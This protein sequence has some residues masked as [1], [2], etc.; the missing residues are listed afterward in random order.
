MLLPSRITRSPE[1]LPQA[2]YLS[3]ILLLSLPR[4][5]SNS[6]ARVFKTRGPKSA[7]IQMT[8]LSLRPRVREKRLRGEERRC[9][10]PHPTPLKS[11]GAS[12]GLAPHRKATLRLH[13]HTRI[14]RWLPVADLEPSWLASTSLRCS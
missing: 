6:A 14:C 5:P 3:F 9:P 7:G 8:D 11:Y 10:R 12:L 4:P 2:T 13:P 1:R